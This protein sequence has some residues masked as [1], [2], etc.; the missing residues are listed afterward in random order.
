LPAIRYKM[1]YAGR[2][3]K[4]K[5]LEMF[6]E[7][8]A[9]ARKKHPNLVLTL[10]GDGPEKQRLA[11][12]VGRLCL[13]NAVIFKESMRRDEVLEE[14]VAHHLVVLPSFS[15]VSPNL[16]MD[17]VTAG[18]PFL[19]TQE[20]GLREVL[21]GAGTW[22]NPMSKEDFAYKLETLLAP[23]ALEEARERMRSHPYRKTWSEVA[24]E[25]ER[26]FKF[27]AQPFN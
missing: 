15:E 5:N 27:S 10:I 23:G 18:T 12:S 22:F 3:L 20:N 7:I 14:I 13:K 25:Y 16:L 8:F 6:L 26:V 1:L 17:A 11:V 2:F 24:E 21:E 9:E 4:L 19:A